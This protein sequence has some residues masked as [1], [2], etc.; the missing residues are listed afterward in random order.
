M[1]KRILVV[2]DEEDFRTIL[3]HVLTRAGYDVVSAPNGTEGLERFAAEKPDALLLD[4]SMPD[5]DG[6]TVT[7]NIRAGGSKTPILMLTVRSRILTVAECL[8]SGV[9]DYVVKPFDT[10]DLLARLKRALETC[11]K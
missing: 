4:L 7:K 1:G 2:D 9:T 3:T 8:A 5:I 11:P 10:D 6:M